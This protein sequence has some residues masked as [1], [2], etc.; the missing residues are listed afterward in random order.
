MCEFRRVLKDRQEWTSE[1]RIERRATRARVDGIKGRAKTGAGGY[2]AQR[3][4]KTV[5]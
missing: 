3:Q 2:N 1:A 4:E 5:D